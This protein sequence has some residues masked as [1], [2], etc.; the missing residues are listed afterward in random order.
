MANNI[1]K[2]SDVELS[3]RIKYHKI[4]KDSYDS[5]KKD[6]RYV[7]LI[8]ALVSACI[9]NSLSSDNNNGEKTDYAPK[10]ELV[11]KSNS[12]IVSSMLALTGFLTTIT[13]VAWG[14]TAL[15]SRSHNKKLM[16]YQ[17]ELRSR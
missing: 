15:E 7:T 16:A 17:N 2:L 12:L 9:Y 6:F 8:L 5:Y 10:Q 1:K 14:F 11:L 3:N 13:G 4:F